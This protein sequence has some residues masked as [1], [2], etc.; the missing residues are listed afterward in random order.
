MKYQREHLREI[1]GVEVKAKKDV[2][3]IYS[4]SLSLAKHVLVVNVGGV[5]SEEDISIK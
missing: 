2:P 5:S 1:S 4:V 3:L